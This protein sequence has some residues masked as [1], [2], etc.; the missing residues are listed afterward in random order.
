MSH[1]EFDEQNIGLYKKQTYVEQKS[2]MFRF[3]EKVGIPEKY[4][5]A[6]LIVVCIVLLGM[7][8]ILFF[9]Y[10]GTGSPKNP[11]PSINGTYS[12]QL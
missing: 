5:N 6:V 12:K 3:V 4:V 7:A 1:V 10:N 2:T 8:G 11:V 9:K